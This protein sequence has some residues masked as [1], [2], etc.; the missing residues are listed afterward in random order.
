MKNLSAT[1]GLIAGLLREILP[2]SEADR[3]AAWEVVES[4]LKAIPQGDETGAALGCIHDRLS[5]SEAE[6]AL[7]FFSAR[8]RVRLLSCSGTSTAALSIN[9]DPAIKQ[10]A[11]R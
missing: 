9:T 6:T 11:K 8:T 3:A 7:V 1:Q 10:Y 5:L 4:R 2:E